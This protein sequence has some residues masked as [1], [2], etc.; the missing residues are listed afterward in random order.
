MDPQERE[1]LRDELL[2]GDVEQATRAM[3]LLLES[4]DPRQ[5]D[6]ADVAAAMAAMERLGTR[7]LSRMSESF[8]LYSTQHAPVT[9]P[10]IVETLE[11]RPLSWPGRLSA[12]V[13]SEVLNHVPGGSS[14]LDRG[15]IVPA[16]IRGVE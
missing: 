11:R 10:V 1:R 5:I 12:A 7:G 15:R 9:L 13:V 16:L 3:S 2:H 6:P 4:E 14:L 8:L